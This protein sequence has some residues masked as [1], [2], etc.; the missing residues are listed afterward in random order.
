MA[1][2]ELNPAYR[3]W[4]EC[5][6]LG[7]PD[8]LVDL[9]GTIICGHPSRQVL[10]VE[11]PVAPAP[12]VEPITCY[13]K[14]EHRV[15]WRQRLTNALAGFGFVSLSRREA[16]VLRELRRAGVGCPDWIAAGEDDRGRAFLLLRGLGGMVDL[17]SFLRRQGTPLGRR[18]PLARQLGEALAHLHETGFA[19]RDLYAKHVLV[20]P[21]DGTITF[22]DWQRSRRQT[23]VTWVQRWRDLAALHA[24]LADDLARTRDRLACLRSYLRA[25]L[26]GRTPRELRRRA[27]ATIAAHARHLLGRRSIREQRQTHLPI[28]SQRLVAWDGDRLWLTPEFQAVLDTETLAWLRTLLAPSAGEGLERRTVAVPGTP[29]A[30]L[31]R[32]QTRS[33]VQCFRSTLLGQRPRSPELAELALLFRLQ[34]HGIGT[35]RLLAF[36]ESFDRRGTLVSFL[37]TEPPAG[38]PI[39]RWLAAADPT[40]RRHVIRRTGD[41]LRRLHTAGCTLSRARLGVQHLP[42]RLPAVVVADPA[43]IRARPHVG[44]RDARRDLLNFLGWLPSL[45]RTDMFRFVQGYGQHPRLDAAGRE[46]VSFL[47]LRGRAG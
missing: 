8:G 34:R 42:G 10:Q 7:R 45:T 36:G 33:L 9:P 13:L 14:R 22:L 3:E 40:G 35:P 15:S 20:D 38:V 39:D 1:I 27:V 31:I 29:R 25:A 19:H 32:R 28:G 23:D 43:G 37:L 30:L 44:P 5:Q 2:L 26:P 16:G 24:S 47:L 4:L 17:P 41:L 18:R 12:Q 21:Q 46:L 11:L 6:R